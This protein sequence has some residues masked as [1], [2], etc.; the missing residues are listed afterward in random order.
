MSSKE[1]I[2]LEEGLWEIDES[3]TARL[4]GSRCRLCGELFFPR[5]KN[6]VCT[7]C[8]GRGL[9][10]VRLSNHGQV[11]TC[12]VVYQRPAGG[13]YKGTVPYAYGVVELPEGIRFMTL[14]VSDDLE[15]I[16]VGSK[17]RLI[18]DPLFEDDEGEQVLTYK[19][20]VVKE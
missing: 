3:G 7:H 2:P 17:V 6:D 18:I 20:E 5:K 10:T 11:V 14:L 13:F 12:T 16:Q 4:L 9:E 15:S 19:F 8:Q 1:S